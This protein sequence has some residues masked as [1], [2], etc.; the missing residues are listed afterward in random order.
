MLVAKGVKN[1][2]LVVVVSTT[3]IE[4]TLRTNLKYIF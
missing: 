1:L 2:Q 3:L 4:K